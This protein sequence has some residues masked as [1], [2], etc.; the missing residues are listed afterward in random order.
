MGQKVL[1]VVEMGSDIVA[2]LG[3]FAVGLA[4]E[5]G[6]SFPFGN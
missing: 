3:H 4:R 5:S 6:L 2:S 1:V